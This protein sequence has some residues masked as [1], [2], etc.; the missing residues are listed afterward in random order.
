[1]ASH[2]AMIM[3]FS[4]NAQ[5]QP[6]QSGAANGARF[7]IMASMFARTGAWEGRRLKSRKN[8]KQRPFWCLP[9][10]ASQAQEKTLSRHVAGFA[11]LNP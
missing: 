6:H 3:Q 9:C 4:R 10:L 2:A 7:S 11:L 8:I 5:K 1:M